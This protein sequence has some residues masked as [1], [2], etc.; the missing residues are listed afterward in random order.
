MSLGDLK[1][2][3]HSDILFLILIEAVPGQVQQPITHFTG[4]WDNFMVHGVN[5]PLISVVI[6]HPSLETCTCDPAIGELFGHN[7]LRS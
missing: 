2:H 1:L 5:R 6:Q 3:D 7:Q 4:P